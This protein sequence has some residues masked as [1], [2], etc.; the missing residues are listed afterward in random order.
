MENGR[1]FFWDRVPL[2][3]QTARTHAR[4]KRSGSPLGFTPQ[5]PN[6][7]PS[8]ARPLP[9]YHSQQFETS[10]LMFSELPRAIGAFRNLWCFWSTPSLNFKSLAFVFHNK[11]KVVRN[12]ARIYFWGSP[13]IQK[14]IWCVPTRKAW[15]KT[16]SLPIRYHRLPCVHIH[17]A[18]RFWGKE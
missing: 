15:H 11:P 18:S 13:E 12:F 5:P 8:G 2:R 17:R 7:D 9:F 6:L 3:S 1:T 16:A 10:I 4:T 14:T